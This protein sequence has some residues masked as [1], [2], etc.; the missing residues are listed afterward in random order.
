[1]N[2]LGHEKPMMGVWLTTGIVVGTVIGSG[3]FMLPV[4]LAPLGRNAIFG[5]LISI[6][7]ALSI[8]FSLAR[9]PRLCGGGGIQSYIEQA[10]G[11]TAGGSA[12]GFIAAWAFWFSNWTGVAAL[13]IAFGAAS[14]RIG[15]PFAANTVLVLALGSIVILT[16]VNAAGVKI[17]GRLN[18]VS[19]A[20]KLLPLIGVAVLLAARL[21]SGHK[22]EPLAS[23]PVTVVNLA[24]ATTLTL[25]AMV[26]F[27]NAT[28]LV[29]KVRDPHR[30][31]PRA[32]L[33][34]T[35]LVGLIYL[36]SSSGV[37]L[38]LP[39]S[40]LGMSG[41]PYADV[42]ATYGGE[43]LVLLAAFAIAVSAFGT[44]LCLILATGELGFSM[45]LRGQMPQLLART[46]TSGTPFLSQGFG[47]LLAILLVLA[48][49]GKSTAG[50]FTFVILLSTSGI[51]VVYT[52]GVLAALRLDPA[53]TTRLTVG[54]A[55]L[56]ILFAFYGSGVEANAWCL[57]LLALG[58]IVYA[59]MR[60][61]NA[62]ATTP[63]PAS[64]RAALPE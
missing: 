50:L 44:L 31:L 7:G 47:S 33:G 16:G 55:L 18:M 12:I 46:T 9:L 3:I 26:G 25:F 28:T 14:S 63:R 1:M 51:L 40:K 27:E 54:V 58:L 59:A 57:V 24:S 41:A 30:T 49:A 2:E 13:A 45:A 19:V 42:F 23:A 6:V 34:G 32:L 36:A 15:V 5:W 64:V 56:F 48:N 8:A 39:P 21:W 4:S 43:G 53:L 29:G 61:L 60:W 11:S 37:T 20:I 52:I 10:F 62:R 38:L 35:V 17:S 22:L